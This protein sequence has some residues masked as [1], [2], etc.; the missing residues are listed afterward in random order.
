MARK[1]IGHVE[2]QWTCPNC[3][4]I[5][6]G[7][8]KTCQNCGSP[9][10][11][12]VEFEQAERQELISDEEKIAAAAAGADIHCP[13]CGTRNPAASPT[14]SQCGGDLVEGTQRKSGRVV[15]A[16][17]TGPVE[18]V[19]CPRCG[20]DNPDTA[21]TCSQCGASMHQEQV[22]A[23]VPAAATKPKSS[24]SRWMLIGAVV[25]LVAL[26]AVLYFVFF[27]TEETTGSVQSV[28]WELSIPIE[29]FGAVQYAGFSDEIPSGAAILAC[30]EKY[31]H[32]QDEPVSNA[33]EVCGTPYTVDDGSGF[34]EVV[35]DCV[36]EVYNEYCEF[37]VD[38]WYI[39]DTI[40]LTGSDH[41]P[42]WPEPALTSEQRLGGDRSETY[43]IIFDTNDGLE[44]Y[45]TN[46]LELFQ[47]AQIGSTWTLVIN[48]IGGVVSI[49][50]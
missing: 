31:H 49:E 13:Y 18:Q 45:T 6:P 1:K 8:I 36:Y 25:V 48:Q 50:R 7:P 28:T 14:C 19:P 4:G 33:E 12:D 46:S 15:G 37:T 40:A 43:V 24:S 17:K 39:A 23:A 29:A 26:C 20:A 42:L 47:Q 3:D 16:F 10:P 9:Q 22:E 35:Q 41:S 11:E 2:L 27:S 38:E 32:T 44:R 30:Q 21:R 5:N 34:A